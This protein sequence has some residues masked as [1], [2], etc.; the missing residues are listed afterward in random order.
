MNLANEVIVFSEYENEN[1]AYS[2]VWL[3]CVSYA[4]EDLFENYKLKNVETE[5]L[6]PN[7]DVVNKKID[8]LSFDKKV[9]IC[10]MIELWGGYMINK[11][12]ILSD[13][14]N[15]SSIAKCSDEAKGLVWRLL[16]A[17]PHRV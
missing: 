5:R 16:T 15:V 10:V 8:K 9:I 4:G 17:F 1:A 13:Y 6:I 3:E 11:Y 14:R 2:A 12:P 7:V